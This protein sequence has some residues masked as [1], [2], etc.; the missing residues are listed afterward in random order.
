LRRGETNLQEK[1]KEE[2]KGYDYYN[3]YY[4]Y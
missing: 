2:Q 4:H 1:N 3:Y